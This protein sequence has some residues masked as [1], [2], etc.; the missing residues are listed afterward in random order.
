MDGQTS[1]LIIAR[2]AHMREGLQVLM[3]AVP[4]VGSICVVEDEP[5]ARGMVEEIKPALILLDYDLANS[6]V[7]MS[8]D[9]LKAQWPQ[10]QYLVFVEDERDRRH[11]KE[12]GADVVLVKG[13]RAATILE[14]IE[15]LLSKDKPTLGSTHKERSNHGNL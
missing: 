5:T 4:Q 8:L 3:Q 15:R 14:T 11:A 7:R 12:A 13:V 2:S 9:Q 1:A 6:E 10:V